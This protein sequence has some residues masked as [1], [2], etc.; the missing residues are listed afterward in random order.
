MS[1]ENQTPGKKSRPVLLILGGIGLVISTLIIYWIANRSND[2]DT[3]NSEILQSITHLD[4]ASFDE[5]DE[6]KLV[7]LQGEIR[8]SVLRDDSFG[9]EVEAVALRRQVWIKRTVEHTEIV[10]NGIEMRLES[11]RKRSKDTLS[12]GTHTK[13][14]RT[15]VNFVIEAN[16]LPPHLLE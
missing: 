4:N 3:A 7:Y 5:S 6:G 2:K 16:N 10:E 11:K 13:S 9:I 15:R 14:W 8:P 1:D 12:F